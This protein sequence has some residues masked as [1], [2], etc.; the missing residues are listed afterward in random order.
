MKGVRIGRLYREGHGNGGKNVK[1]MRERGRV[2]EWRVVRVCGRC[3]R[4]RSGE[5]VGERGPV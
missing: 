2:E 1:R 5:I 3:G 4:E